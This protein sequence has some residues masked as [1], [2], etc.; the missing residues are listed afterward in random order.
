VIQFRRN[1]DAFLYDL[2][3]SHGTYLGKKK[4]KSNAYVPIPK[5]NNLIKFGTSSRLYILHTSDKDSDEDDDNVNSNEDQEHSP[6]KVETY[7]TLLA[8]KY[9]PQADIKEL[10]KEMAKENEDVNKV[11]EDDMLDNFMNNLNATLSQ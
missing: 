6:E 10:E 2:G 3:S 5:N 7:E 4:I 9:T 1:G 8:Q 11:D